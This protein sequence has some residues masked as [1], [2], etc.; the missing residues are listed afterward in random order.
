MIQSHQI[1]GNIYPKYRSAS[2]HFVRRT[3]GSRR[4]G[5]HSLE[6]LITNYV[7]NVSVVI[8]EVREIEKRLKH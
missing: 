3:L 6:E 4:L 1:E 5:D 8:N 7:I 2:K